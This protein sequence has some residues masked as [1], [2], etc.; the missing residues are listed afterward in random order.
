[1]IVQRAFPRTADSVPAAR[2]FVVDT[3]NDIPKEIVDRA[4][5]MVSELATNAIRHGGTDFE[6]R[7]KRTDDELS[8]EIEDS[9]EGSPV[10]RRAQPNDASGRGLHIVE[11][12]A[13]EWGVRNTK[14]R[15]GKTVWFRLSLAPSARDGSNEGTR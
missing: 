12:L 9:G 2:H 7:I 11:A 3:V 15:A 10:V 14:R 8:V 5:L 6:L 4:A 13:D 1:M